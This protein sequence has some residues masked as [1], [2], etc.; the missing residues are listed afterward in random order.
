[1]DLSE[2]KHIEAPEKEAPMPLLEKWTR[3]T[4]HGYDRLFGHVYHHPHYQDGELI[5]T[6]KIIHLSGEYAQC[7]SRV[8]KL[9]SKA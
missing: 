8:Y 6:S 1:M 3:L 4:A 2:A 7:Y 5:Y 9:G